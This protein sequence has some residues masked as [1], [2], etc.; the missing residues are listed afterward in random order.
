MPGVA[1]ADSAGGSRPFWAAMLDAQREASGR[2]LGRSLSDPAIPLFG[3]AAS[4]GHRAHGGPPHFE[5]RPGAWGQARAAAHAV[6]RPSASLCAVVGP[7]SSCR[8][9]G[10]GSVKQARQAQG[11]PAPMRLRGLMGLHIACSGRLGRSPRR[12][13]LCGAAGSCVSPQTALCA[14]LTAPRSVRRER[15]WASDGCS[16]RYAARPGPSP[17]PTPNAPPSR[18]RSCGRRRR[19]RRAAKRPPAS[20]SPCGSR[21]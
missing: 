19:A 10:C 15:L 7:E 14:Q 3:R 1:A 6:G 20:P 17:R 12:R 13:P 21:P 4:S 11:Y 8:P 18:R 9:A 16:G 5:V 2:A